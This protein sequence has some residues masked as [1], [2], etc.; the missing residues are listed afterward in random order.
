MSNNT[1]QPVNDM[2][3]RPERTPTPSATAIS[4]ASTILRDGSERGARS[5]ASDMERGLLEQATPTAQFSDTE[6]TVEEFKPFQ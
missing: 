2:A 3:T 4:R 5:P 6:S 1:Q